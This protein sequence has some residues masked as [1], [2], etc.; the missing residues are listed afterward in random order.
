MQVS[1]RFLLVWLI[2]DPFPWLAKSPVYSSMLLA[3]SATEVIRYSYFALNLSDSVP[4]PFTW[5]RYS[6]FFVLYPIGI[7]SEC[8]LIWSAIED[9]RD[10]NPIYAYGLYA[11]LLIYI[12]GKTLQRSWIEVKADNIGS[13]ILYTHMMAQRRKIMKSLKVQNSKASN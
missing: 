1:S 10:Q 5:L 11:I 7:T 4:K 2:I 9:A 13:Y 8:Y 12:P 3:W 6:S